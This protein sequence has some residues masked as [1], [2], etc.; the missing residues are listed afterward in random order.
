MHLNQGGDKTIL[1]DKLS[2]LKGEI[3]DA[4]VMNKNALLNFLEEEMRDANEKNLLFS[5][6]IFSKKR[7]II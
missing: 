4:T 3:I 1:L 5:L 6:S 7:P 2:L